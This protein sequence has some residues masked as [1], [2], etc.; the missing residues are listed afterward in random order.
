[1]NIPT[2]IERIERLKN[3]L[4]YWQDPT[5]DSALQLGEEALKLIKDMRDFEYWGVPKLLP[6]ETKE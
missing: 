2:A 4:K 5:K 6:G 3:D 1:M